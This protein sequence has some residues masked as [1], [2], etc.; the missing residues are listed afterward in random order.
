M[1]STAA[2]HGVVN[3]VEQLCGDIGLLT[4][5]NNYWGTADPDSIAALI[6]DHND[7]EDRCYEV[8]FEPFASESTPVVPVG[9]SDLKSLFR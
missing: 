6:N 2:D 1:T 4:M 5:T 7:S 8:I 3:V 9:L